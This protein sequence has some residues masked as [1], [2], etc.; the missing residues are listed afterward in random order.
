MTIA[1][2]GNDKLSGDAGNDLVYGGDGNDQILGGAG[3]DSLIGGNGDD[4]ITGGTGIDRMRGDAGIDHFVFANGD[5]GVG[6]SHDVI[7]SFSSND[8]IDLSLVDANSGVAGDQAFTWIG[9]N[10]FSAPGQLRYEISGSDKIIQAS[11]DGDSRPSSKS[12]CRAMPARPTCGD[13]IL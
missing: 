13:F 1:R 2:A 9:H 4:A 12:C 3:N 10:A 5:T 6:A 11:T 7:V 8:L